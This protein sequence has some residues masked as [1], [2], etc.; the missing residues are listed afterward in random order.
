MK[1]NGAGDLDAVLNSACSL[2]I[3]SSGFPTI[4]SYVFAGIRFSIIAVY[5]SIVLIFEALGRK[6][7]V[8]KEK[9]DE[10]EDKPK[11]ESKS[12][13]ALVAFRFLFSKLAFFTFSTGFLLNDGGW[14]VTIHS[15]LM[16]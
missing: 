12:D 2:H 16:R 14:R 8:K 7:P 1:E 15:R 10:I 4:Y 3:L 6:K 11:E 13:D 9:K 5:L